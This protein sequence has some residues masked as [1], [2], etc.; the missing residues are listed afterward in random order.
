MIQIKLYQQIDH[1]HLYPQTGSGQVNPITE[2]QP[3][4]LD[5]NLVHCPNLQAK[6]LRQGLENADQKVNKNSYISVIGWET[7]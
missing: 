6:S 7:N 5:T 2:I 1:P 3:I 4:N